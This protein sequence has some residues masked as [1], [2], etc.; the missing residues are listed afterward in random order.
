MSLREG[1][2]EKKVLVM[3]QFNEARTVVE[4]LNRAYRYVDIIV[5]VDDG[6][7]DTSYGLIE[8]W[9]RDK[10]KV[11]LIR[12]GKNRGMSGALLAGFCY[13]YG[14]LEKGMVDP[15]DIVIN[16]DADGQH[17]AEEIP[18]AIEFMK[19]HGYDIVLTRRDLSGYP[20]LKQIGNWGLS[21]WAS[22]LGGVKYHDVECGFRFM[23]AAV[24]PH[25][26]KYF[27]GRRYGCAQEIGIITALLDFKINNE[28][29]TRINY[30]REG[31]RVRDGLTNL[32]MGLLAFL[33]V[34][35]GIRN[36]LSKLLRR[37]FRDAFVWDPG[38]EGA[39][40]VD[41]LESPRS[42]IS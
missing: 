17:R 8:A 6:S 24:I 5:V 39:P 7:T 29:P 25:L 1:V 10:E 3:P 35:L 13:V 31:A 15:E 34:K 22:F 36:D 40:V 18:S 42:A 11:C 23:G 33:R 9:M 28:L 37:V 12:L 2:L 30:Y 26:L 21:L 16:I 41:S 14:L 19:R 4:V 38:I 32:G 27:T 20:R